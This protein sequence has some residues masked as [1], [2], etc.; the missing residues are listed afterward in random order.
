MNRYCP[1]ALSFGGFYTLNVRVT[2]RS[3]NSEYKIL[4]ERSHKQC[5]KCR[6]LVLSNT[7][8]EHYRTSS[9]K[10]IMYS[11]IGLLP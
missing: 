9:R 5:L 7:R 6:S 2:R 4:D 3:S 11:T 10:S 8:S 1:H